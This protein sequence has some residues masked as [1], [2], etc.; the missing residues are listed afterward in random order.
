M[1]HLIFAVAFLLTMVGISQAAIIEQT[2]LFQGFLTRADN[3]DNVSVNDPFTGTFNYVFDENQAPE[4]SG[5]TY[6]IYELPQ[7]SLSFNV[8]DRL[9]FQT[10]VLSATINNTT[11]ESLVFQDPTPTFVSGA[12]SGLFFDDLL[13]ELTGITLES[14]G[15]SRIQQLGVGNFSTVI[16]NGTTGLEQALSGDFVNSF[17]NGPTQP[18]PEPATLLLVGSGLAVLARR[19]L[20]L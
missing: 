14:P 17:G 3:W 12:T 18:I 9:V 6:S 16:Y 15:L 13:V 19:K 8:L 11:L 7:A 4:I 10:S 20:S 5:P 2:I 1:K